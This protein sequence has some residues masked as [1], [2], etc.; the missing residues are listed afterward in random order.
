MPP[1]LS[2]QSALRNS[3]ELLEQDGVTTPCFHQFGIV[4]A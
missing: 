1:S 3:L 2:S 4:P